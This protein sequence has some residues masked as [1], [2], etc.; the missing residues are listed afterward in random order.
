MVNVRVNRRAAGLADGKGVPQ[1][2]CSCVG[3]QVCHDNGE[4]PYLAMC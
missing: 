1:P 3:A 2:L 4:M